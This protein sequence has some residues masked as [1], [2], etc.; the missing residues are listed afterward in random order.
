M[1]TA[2]LLRSEMTAFAGQQILAPLTAI[3]PL[4]FTFSFSSFGL[5]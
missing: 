2:E 5:A 1:S 4:P 3:S